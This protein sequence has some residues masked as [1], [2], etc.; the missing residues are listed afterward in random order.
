MI[1]LTRE[2]WC[3]IYYALELKSRELGKGRYG[4]EDYIGQDADWVT[5]LDAIMKKI[6]PDGRL[7]ARDGVKRSK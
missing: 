5:H 3:E 6:G 4:N 2:D 1:S 7:A